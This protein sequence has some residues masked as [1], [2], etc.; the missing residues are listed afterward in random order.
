MTAVK[1]PV[2]G[3]VDYRGFDRPAVLRHQP[4][5]RESPAIAVASNSGA[6][7]APNLDYL[8]IPAFLRRQAE[9]YQKA[10]PAEGKTAPAAEPRQR[11]RESLVRVLFNH[12][13]FITIR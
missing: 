12:N 1:E 2:E 4:S 7:T 5:R 8:D 13:D 6:A 10:S 9:L 11:A 3:P